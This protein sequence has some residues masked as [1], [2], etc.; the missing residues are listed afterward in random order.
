MLLASVS[1]LHR[2]FEAQNERKL[3]GTEVDGQ[4]HAGSEESAFVAPNRLDANCNMGAKPKT[5]SGYRK[6]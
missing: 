2:L 5:L 1:P 6:N 3:L 4:R